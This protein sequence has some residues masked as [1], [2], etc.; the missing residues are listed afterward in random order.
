MK[1]ICFYCFCFVL[2]LGRGHR[3]FLVHIL[4]IMLKASLAEGFPWWIQVMND[5]IANHNKQ[6]RKDSF[7]PVLFINSWKKS[8]QRHSEIAYISDLYLS[9]TPKKKSKKNKSTFTTLLA[10]AVSR[11]LSPL[12]RQDFK[13]IWRYAENMLVHMS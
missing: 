13:F 5:L 4:I 1:G 9:K 10:V 11:Y 7:S 6:R 8:Y 3:D 12:L 2:W